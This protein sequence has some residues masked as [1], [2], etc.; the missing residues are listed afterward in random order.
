M[1]AGSIVED[2]GED[3]GVVGLVLVN[4]DLENRSRGHQL[5]LHDALGRLVSAL[6]VDGRRTRH[7]ESHDDG[8]ATRRFEGVSAKAAPE[9]EHAVTTA[10]SEPVVAGGQ[11]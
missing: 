5:S 7:A 1:L 3:F 4:E 10:H 9:V 8:A 2:L 11:H 6:F